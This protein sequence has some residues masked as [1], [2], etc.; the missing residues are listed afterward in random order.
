MVGIIATSSKQLFNTCVPSDFESSFDV[1]CI[2]LN[3]KR[4]G[5]HSPIFNIFFISKWTPAR[6]LNHAYPGP[7]LIWRTAFTRNS[8]NKVCKVM[9]KDWPITTGNVRISS[10]WGDEGLQWLLFKRADGCFLCSS[11]IKSFT[12]YLGCDFYVTS[13]MCQWYL[14]SDDICWHSLTAHFESCSHRSC[15]SIWVSK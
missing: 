2:Y 3:W 12:S 8:Y 6:G 13:F 14:P 4:K 1:C 9:Q 11:V 7:C 15:V 5:L 10:G